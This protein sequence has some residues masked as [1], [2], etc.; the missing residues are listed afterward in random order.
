[1]AGLSPRQLAF[2]SFRVKG[3]KPWVIYIPKPPALH[4]T[5]PILD[6]STTTRVS[7]GFVYHTGHFGNRKGFLEQAGHW[8]QQKEFH[9][10]QRAGITHSW[11]T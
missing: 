4:F 7:W 8:Q 5:N 10:N 1:M 11:E 9:V 2:L 6:R 3:L